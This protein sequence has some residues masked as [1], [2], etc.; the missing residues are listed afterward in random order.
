MTTRL[1][2][3]RKLGMA[4]NTVLCLVGVGVGVAAL[5]LMLNES[6]P[7]LTPRDWWWGSLG[8]SLVL[9]LTGILGM[10]FCGSPL[11]DSDSTN[12]S[13]NTTTLLTKQRSAC[14]CYLA[15]AIMMAVAMGAA[16]RYT[17]AVTLKPA[18]VRNHLSQTWNRIP[19]ESAL[20]IESMGECCGFASYK[21]RI[22][23]P[24]IRR[25]VERGCASTMIKY[26]ERSTRRLITIM[27]TVLVASLIGVVLAVGLWIWGEREQVFAVVPVP[28]EEDRE[29]TLN[30]PGTP[31]GQ[32]FDDWHRTIFQ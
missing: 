16:L 9:V 24:C 5:A 25:Q 22:Q 12:T 8:V 32:S 28:V 14:K 11:Y 19:E 13:T 21:D 30:L 7:E 1:E 3:A 29:G 6:R 4:Y 31:K 27:S 2:R 26:Y 20:A 23:E 18:S 17:T 10:V 15:L